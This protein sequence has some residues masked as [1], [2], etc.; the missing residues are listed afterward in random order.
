MLP[1]GLHLPKPIF[2]FFFILLAWRFAGIWRSHWLPNRLTLFILTGIGLGLLYSQHQGM[3]GRDA[4]VAL[5]VVAL[6]LKLLEIHGKR[7]VYL[8]V[9]LAFVVAASQFL[10]EQSILM[11]AYIL[12]VCT[13]LLATLIIENSLNIKAPAALKSAAGII[14]QALPITLVV[15]VLFPR[16]EAPHWLW[17]EDETRGK[18]GLSNTLEPGSISDLSLSDE[19]VFRVKFNG[20]PPPPN[21][22]YWRGPVFLFTDGTRWMTPMNWQ[23]TMYG[24]EYNRAFRSHSPEFSGTAY[25]YTLL[26]EPQQQAWVFAL[27]L[28]AQFDQHV[29][30]N[31]LLQLQ[32]DKNPGNRNEYQITSYP[33]YNT[34]Q[35][36]KAE[37]KDSLQLPEPA[38]EKILTLLKQLHGIDAKPEVF[39]Q[40]VLNYFRVENFHYTL[41]PPL[42]KEHP[43]ETFLFTER[44]GFCSHYATAFV[45]L[46]RAAGIPARVIGGYQGGQ[47]NK[48]GDF[49]EIRQADAH[50]WAE[51]WLDGKGWSRF[52]PTAAVA[53]ER[54]DRGVNIDLQLASG[55]VNF[56]PTTDKSLLSWLKQSR[57]LW[58]S[59]DYKWQRWVINYNTDSQ[60]QFLSKLGI[61]DWSSL[62]GWLSTC[63][64]GIT[65]LLS[66]FLLKNQKINQDKTLQVYR[67]FCRKMAKAG[68]Q[69]QPG[70]GPKS[71][72]ERTKNQR[73]DLALQISKITAIFIR[74]RYEQT[75]AVGDLQLLKKL[76]RELRI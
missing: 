67:R 71:F 9:F 34:G 21:Q 40:N 36:S 29:Y 60:S 52:D 10:Y 33:H 39:I 65:L 70:E 73:Q 69:I 28:A 42:M 49:L 64:A 13:V 58:L 37:Q 22:R 2:I 16:L 27:E 24:Y 19:L 56:S 61:K 74:L 57:Q 11:S 15:F 18:S 53:P 26:M 47:I 38:S 7:E 50:A 43:I 5:F 20:E 75:A 59:I 54:I 6:G 72:S 3:F 48:I 4:G 25:S 76:I 8:V 12:L 63:V 62:A 30:L 41:R 46:L 55:A 35:L 68:M 14:L 32:T 17:L 23:G 45:Y 44:A 31:Q 51:V 66:C 1:H